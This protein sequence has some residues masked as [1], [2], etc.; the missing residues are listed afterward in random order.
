VSERMNTTGVALIGSGYIS[1]YH[2]CGLKELPEVEL[3][4]LCSLDGEQSET[5]GAAIAEALMSALGV[6]K[7]SLTARARSTPIDC[8]PDRCQGTPR[9]D[10]PALRRPAACR[11]DD[12]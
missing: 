2:A 6:S 10:P 12:R 11:G 1:H 8:F 5:D 3:R 7:N 4:A 9:G